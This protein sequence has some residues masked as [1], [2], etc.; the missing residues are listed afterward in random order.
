MSGCGRSI[1][2]RVFWELRVELST[3]IFYFGNPWVD[4]YSL[5]GGGSCAALRGEVEI[6]IV[7]YDSRR[8]SF[9][10]FYDDM[11]SRCSLRKWREMT[12][13]S[14]LDDFIESADRYTLSFSNG[15]IAMA[16]KEKY[17][18]IGYGIHL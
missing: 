9:V 15:C 8:R 7:P 4:H 17:Y 14:N 16:M 10:T 6:W 1:G 11:R 3:Y 12:N 18:C 13:G 2:K 5:S